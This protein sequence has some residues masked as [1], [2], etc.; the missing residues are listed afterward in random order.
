MSETVIPMRRAE[1]PYKQHM[2]DMLD[3]IRAEVENG[4]IINLMALAIHPDQEFTNY[5]ADEM[6]AVETVGMLER[7]KMSLLLKMS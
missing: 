5:S 1:T 7:H 6:N 4:S 3:G 2:L